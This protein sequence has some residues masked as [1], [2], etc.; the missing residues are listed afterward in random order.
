MDETAAIFF[1]NLLHTQWSSVLTGGCFPC[2]PCEPCCL[3]G[4]AG[5][6][7]MR[8]RADALAAGASIISAIEHICGG[9]PD[10]PPASDEVRTGAL[11]T[12]LLR[13]SAVL[14]K[15]EDVGCIADDPP[16]L[17]SRVIPV[18]APVAACSSSALGWLCE[19]KK[20]SRGLLIWQ[21]HSVG[22]D[23]QEAEAWLRFH[24]LLT[25]P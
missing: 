6:V 8:G 1:F 14:E 3:Q 19:Y 15:V 24:A 18:A 13:V 5:T 7:P 9:G 11:V 25:L 22:Q 12:L 2:K 17:A 4:H 23:E 21:E 20:T 10:A 16:A